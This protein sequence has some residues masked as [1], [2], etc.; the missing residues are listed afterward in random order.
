M[1]KRSPPTRPRIT[2]DYLAILKHQPM[3]KPII[4]LLTSV[5]FAATALAGQPDKKAI[6]P[7]EPEPAQPWRFTLSMPFWLAWESG[8]MGIKSLDSQ[9]DLTPRDIVPEIDMAIAVRGEARKGRFGIMGEYSFSS[10]S[11]GIGNSNAIISK[12]DVQT[13]Q[14]IAEMALSWR[15]IEGEKGYLD[16]FAGVRYTCLYQNLGIHVSEGVIDDRADRFV[17]KLFELAARAA[18]ERFEP[19][20]Q[21]LVRT[22]LDVLR[23]RKPTLPQGPIGNEILTV[24]ERRIGAILNRR[25]AELDGAI[26]SGIRQRIDDAKD[27]L[28][29]EISRALKDELRRSVSRQDDWWDPYVGLKGRYYLSKPVYLTG[30][31]D[32]GGFGVGADFSWQVNT[33]IGFQITR[34]LFS[35][36][37]YRAYDVDYDRGGL[38]YDVLTQGVEIN[39]GFNF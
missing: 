6:T 24:L 32:I 26:R 1:P 19:E 3:H 2:S 23:N 38:I 33:G 20:V 5:V 29:H 12:V 16:V 36:I 15:L 21:R 4:P 22:E 9:L 27:R 25:R 17:D 14:H 31:V 8:E 28:S 13:D 30:R 11:D 7:T 10:V 34:H 35:E 18:R 39:T 37:T